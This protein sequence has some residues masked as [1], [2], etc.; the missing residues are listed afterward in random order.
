M[1]TSITV[2]GFE[3][4]VASMDVAKNKM[5][6]VVLDTLEDAGLRTHANAVR[7]LQRGPKSGR[8]YKRGNI[9]HQASSPGQ[10][11]ASNTGRLVSSVEIEGIGTNVV[12]VGTALT[13]GAY[14][15]FGTSEMSA[16]PWLTPSFEAALIEIDK[17]AKKQFD[18]KF[19]HTKGGK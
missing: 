18:I 3:E 6:E 7:G 5:R 2:T 11:P 8:I 9:T 13:Y 10:Y 12:R 15:E 16:R 14:L 19:K 1:R 17:D 4:A